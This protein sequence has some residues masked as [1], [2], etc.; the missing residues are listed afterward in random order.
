MPDYAFMLVER[1]L[2]IPNF[3]LASGGAGG[4]GGDYFRE[5]SSRQKSVFR[6]N[7]RQFFEKKEC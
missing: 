7:K 1:H 4:L 5:E 2:T 3:G 6:D